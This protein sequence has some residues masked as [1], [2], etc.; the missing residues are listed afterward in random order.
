[1]AN[2][3]ELQ[4]PKG[5]H[6]SVDVGA[7][8]SYLIANYKGGRNESF[9]YGGE[10]KTIWYDYDLTSAY[11]TGMSYFTLPDYY[12]GNLIDPKVLDQWNSEDLL[13]GY[14]IVNCNFKFPNEVK[15]H[16]YHVT[17]IK[18]QQFILLQVQLF[19]PSLILIS[20]TSRL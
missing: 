1:M 16:L 7:H 3:E 15:Y 18:L 20:K 13:N 5:L 4:T 8:M 2:A 19:Y 14:L 11:T 10:E 9:M 17:S 6:S 12:R